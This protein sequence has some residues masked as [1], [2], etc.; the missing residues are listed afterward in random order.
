MSSLL[1]VVGR[2][3]SAARVWRQVCPILQ[4]LS[5]QRATPHLSPFSS[6]MAVQCS[7][8]PPK[9]KVQLLRT[10]FRLRD[11]EWWLCEMPTPSI[12]FQVVEGSDPLK[13]TQSLIN[14]PTNLTD[15]PLWR[16]RLL[17]ST[18]EALPPRP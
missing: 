11:K 6:A 17:S 5:Q 12:D 3:M 10:C 7:H 8:R 2:S 9:F 4:C 15:G 1:H 18:P 16:V 14:M 13:E